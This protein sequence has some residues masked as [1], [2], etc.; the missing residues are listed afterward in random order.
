MEMRKGEG[1]VQGGGVRVG[2]VFGEAYLRA[3]AGS[4]GGGRRR[5]CRV[6]GFDPR[7]TVNRLGT[8]L[9]SE[10]GGGASGGRERGGVS[11]ARYDRWNWSAYER[12]MVYGELR[13]EH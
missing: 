5:P 10:R 7:A 13:R 8:I 9:A 2:R 4:S 11:R 3:V 12:G 6:V 1:D